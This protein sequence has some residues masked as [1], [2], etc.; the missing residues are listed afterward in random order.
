MKRKTNCKSR[1]DTYY[2]GISRVA[3]FL[4]S[5]LAVFTLKAVEVT[6]SDPELKLFLDPLIPEMLGNLLL[7]CGFVI[8]GGVLFE[9]LFRREY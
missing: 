9:F 6:G 4:T 7:I 3:L 1:A 5:V 2:Y 8:A